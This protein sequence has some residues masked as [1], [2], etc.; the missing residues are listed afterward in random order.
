L[1]YG[2]ADAVPLNE[3]HLL[4]TRIVA[5]EFF[6]FGLSDQPNIPDFLNALIPYKCDVFSDD[7]N[8]CLATGFSKNF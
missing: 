3:A 8:I 2:Y 7:Q 4:L 5:S 6:S 1:A